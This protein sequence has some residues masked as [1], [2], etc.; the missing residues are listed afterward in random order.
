MN[1]DALEKE[2]TDQ[3]STLRKWRVL[4]VLV[5]TLILVFLRE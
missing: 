4:R 5:I 3:L 2:Q 1:I